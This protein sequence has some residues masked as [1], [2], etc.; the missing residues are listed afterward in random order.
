VV[1][2]VA[3]AAGGSLFLAVGHGFADALG[4]VLIG[5]ICGLLIDLI[6]HRLKRRGEML[7]AGLA[8][9]LLGGEG[10]RLLGLESPLLVGMAAGFTIVNRDRRDVRVFRAIN[11][12]E[13]PI[14]ALFFTL[15]GAHLDVGA[16]V[17]A[18]A[19]GITYAVLRVVGKMCG[20]FVGATLSD[21]LDTVRK[22]LGFALVPQ[23]GVAIGLILTI[24]ANEALAEYAAIVMP[25]VLAGVV[26]SELFGPL[27]AKHAVVRAGEA[28]RAGTV[29]PVGEEGFPP[30]ELGEIELVP[31]TWAQLPPPGDGSDTVV[32]GVPLSSYRMLFL[33][34]IVLRIA[35]LLLAVRI[36][37][38][39]S[40][41]TR[42]VVSQLIGATPL[43]LIHFPVGLFRSETSDRNAETA[44]ATE[45]T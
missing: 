34:S 7:T 45:N 42:H 13:P 25:V 11:D 23:A 41:G 6:V 5:I 28:G 3:G 12:F 33:V 40:H 37:E 26:L 16:L 29:E 39:D 36:R 9:I 32:F 21:S 27:S 4:S 8:L 20:A 18:G 35:S 1:S 15:A 19:V 30:G 31:W 24:Q 44:A 43:R 22:Y 17:T 2:T 38:T 14:Y 10:S